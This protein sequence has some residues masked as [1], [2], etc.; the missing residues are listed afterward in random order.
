MLASEMMMS[1]LQAATDRLD[2][3]LKELEEENDELKEDMAGKYVAG[4]RAAIEQ[5]KALFP[6]IDGD[7]LAQADFLKKVEDGK[8]VPFLPS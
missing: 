4:F 1:K 6:D 2:G 8:L 5:V 3:D 7:V